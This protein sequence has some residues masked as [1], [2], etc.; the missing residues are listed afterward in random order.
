MF[1]FLQTGYGFCDAVF[2]PNLIW[3][4]KRM[5]ADVHIAVDGSAQYGSGILL[6]ERRQVRAASYE[7]DSKGCFANDHFAQVVKCKSA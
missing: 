1:E 4:K 7:A 5:R 6:I 2:G 3:L